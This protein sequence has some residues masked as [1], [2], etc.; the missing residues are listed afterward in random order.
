MGRTCPRAPVPG[1]M[2]QAGS[3][4]MSEPGSAVGRRPRRRPSARPTLQAPGEKRPE[5]SRPRSLR[6]QRPA[7]SE[8]KPRPPP[9]PNK[10]SQI[11]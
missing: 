9:A 11:S 6:L 8:S 3:A 5:V 4:L 1:R 7:P 10:G 2:A